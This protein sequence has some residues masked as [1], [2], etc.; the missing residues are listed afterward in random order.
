MNRVVLHDAET[1]RWVRFSNPVE[2]IQ[3]HDL[4]EVQS[5]LSFVETQVE[6]KGLHAA[7]FISYEAAPA[8][9]SAFKVVPSSNCP[10]LWF[11]L[12]DSPEPIDLP[13]PTSKRDY[14]LG[15]WR[16]SVT[17]DEYASA[18]QRIREYIAEGDT[19]QVNYSFRLKTKFSGDVWSFFLRLAH[20]QQS[21]HSAFI[22]TEQFAICSASPELFFRLDGSDLVSRPMKG[23]AQRGLTFADDKRMGEW[24]QASE[25]NRSENVMIVDMVRNDIGRVAEPSSISVPKL[26]EVERY[27]TVWQMTSTV[28]GKTD[29]PVGSIMSALFPCA[30]ITGAPKVRSTE[31]IAELESLPRRVYTGAIGYIAPQRKAQFNVAIRTV[32]IDRTS[33]EAE[34]GVGGGIVWGS[35]PDDEYNECLNKAKVLTEERP[36]FSLLETM[37]WA[38]DQGY[39]LLE[40]HLRRLSDSAEYFGYNCDVVEVGRMLEIAAKGF[41]AAPQKVRLLVS[42]GGMIHIEHKA[43]LLDRSQPVRLRLAATPVDRED[44]FLYHKTTHRV[45]YDRAR[46]ECS[47]CDDVLLWNA[48]GEVTE[49]TIANIVVETEKGLITPPVECGLLAGTFRRWLLEQGKV[50]EQK[51]MVEELRNAKA[52]CLVNSVRQWQDARFL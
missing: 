33:G 23:T 41:A 19:Y 21:R 16:P 9:D 36:E 46:T 20:S 24:L 38:P 37:L 5:A 25:K 48:Q 51:I 7:G 3:A 43:M 12:Y 22:E 40:Y 42:S 13:R 29:Q 26:F 2:I 6:K 4:G 31:I 10:L 17:R 1:K 44:V 11:G 15:E 35:T 47:D 14:S 8:F 32:L 39:F 27:P 34:Y 28:K 52:I 49:S 50:R 18:I 45:V 30:S